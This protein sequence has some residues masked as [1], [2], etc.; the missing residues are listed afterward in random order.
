MVWSLPDE[1]E[2]ISSFWLSLAFSDVVT[3]ACES[4]SLRFVPA[5]SGGRSNSGRRAGPEDAAE[6]RLARPV[7]ADMSITDS[8]FEEELGTGGRSGSESDDER[9]AGAADLGGASAGEGPA[10]G[11]GF[12]RVSKSSKELPEKGSPMSS[13]DIKDVYIK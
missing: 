8:F 2:S 12:V 10:L 6:E 13:P 4:S 3:A 9:G 1:P 5:N 11:G 7:I